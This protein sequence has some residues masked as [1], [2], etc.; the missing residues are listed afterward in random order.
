M[1]NIKENDKA[2]I[3]KNGED[4]EVWLKLFWT[5]GPKKYQLIEP[6]DEDFGVKAWTAYSFEGAESI[7]EEIT[8]GVRDIRPMVES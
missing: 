2:I 4:F 7:F 8:S 6:N 1:K 5:M 3:W